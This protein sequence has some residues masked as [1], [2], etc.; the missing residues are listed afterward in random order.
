MRGT[1]TPNLAGDFLSLQEY[2]ADRDEW[3]I[4]NTARVNRQGRYLLEGVPQVSGA[5]VLLRIKYG[6]QLR[7]QAF[8]DRYVSAGDFQVYGWHHLDDLAVVAS[9][10]DHHGGGGEPGWKIGGVDYPHT[11]DL[12]DLSEPHRP[13][14]LEWRLDQRC[15]EFDGFAGVADTS[16]VASTLSVGS[17]TSG[18]WSGIA[19]PGAP[20]TRVT[21]GLAG[22]QTLR[23]GETSAPASAFALFGAARVKCAFPRSGRPDA[24]LGS[25]F[26]ALLSRRS[27]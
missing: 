13:S 6:W 25:V 22:V 19:M 27:G 12:L 15:T 11:V 9:S 16:S 4:V 17:G 24:M 20:A 8:V 10:N 5:A 7:T 23:L 21:V 1:T 18:I 3:L 26:R 14:W 2:D